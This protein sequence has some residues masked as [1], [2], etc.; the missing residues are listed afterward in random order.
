ML[1]QSGTLL[2]RRAANLV[3]DITVPVTGRRWLKVGI[4]EAAVVAF[5]WS[6]TR[7]GCPPG[8]HPLDAMPQDRHV[9]LFRRDLA[10][11]KRR[12]SAVRGRE[13]GQRR[14]LGWGCVRQ[15]CHGLGGN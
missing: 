13:G 9:G 3:I 1:L 5:E 11:E 6:Q 10:K 8:A 7:L 14:Q 15:V 12:G 4:R 2:N